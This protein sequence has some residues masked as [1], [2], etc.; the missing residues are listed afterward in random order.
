[1]E[2]G[3]EEARGDASLA[4]EGGGEAAPAP[5]GWCRVLVPLPMPGALFSPL[6]VLAVMP[7]KHHNLALGGGDLACKGRRRKG[8][9]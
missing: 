4:G 8:G 7:P 1:M 2:R 3:G 9:H 6:D 5:A